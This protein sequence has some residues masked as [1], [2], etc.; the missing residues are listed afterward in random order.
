MP[1]DNEHE[2]H[3]YFI[4]PGFIPM[5]REEYE[6]FIDRQQAATVAGHHALNAWLLEQS[7][8]SLKMIDTLLL[9]TD[10]PR[11]I[12]LR[13][14]ISGILVSRGFCQICDN[15]HDPSAEFEEMREPANEDPQ[16]ETEPQSPYPTMSEKEYKEN[17][18]KWNVTPDE[19]NPPQIICLGCGMTYVSLEDRMRR[20][21]GMDG[22]HGCQHKSAHG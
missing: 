2:H 19:F 8:D 14:V 20:A 6:Q 15:D 10:A 7:N 4:G 16:Q 18:E 1:D 11:Q 12:M 21:P 5:T 13:G 17:C 9:G 22:C 3:E